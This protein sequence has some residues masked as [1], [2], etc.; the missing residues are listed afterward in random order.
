MLVVAVAARPPTG[1]PST[2]RAPSGLRAPGKTLWADIAGHYVL[3]P[4]ERRVLEDSGRL[5]DVIGSSN[6]P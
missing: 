3:R 6:G 4:E 2:G 5:A 1:G